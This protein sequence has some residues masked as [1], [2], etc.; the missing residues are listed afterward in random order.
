MIAKAFSVHLLKS[1]EPSTLGV[2]IS[3]LTGL[4][5]L[6][7]YHSL[8]THNPFKHPLVAI[9]GSARKAKKPTPK[10]T[11]EQTQKLLTHFKENS[12]GDMRNRCI[13]A[14]LLGGGLRR[15]EIVNL[16][17]GDIIPAQPGTPFM[18]ARL[19]YTKG[20]V[21]EEQSLPNWAADYVMDWIGY[22]CL[23]GAKYDEPLIDLGLE[24]LHKAWKR[25][26]AACGIFGVGLH[27]CRVTAANKLM[28]D[29]YSAIEIQ[30]FMRHK[31]L[32]TTINYMRRETKASTNPGRDLDYF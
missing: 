21:Y 11:T 31:H 15:Q 18:T 4:Y 9:K 25:M 13:L 19:Y 27:S 22:R 24:G 5:D 23:G 26:C 20:S 10:L 1:I 6:F 29:G 8:I 28:N 7:L 32:V 17:L 30:Q 14:L 3:G 12:A 16:C 2:Y